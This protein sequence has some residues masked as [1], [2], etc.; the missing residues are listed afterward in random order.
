M[1]TLTTNSNFVDA[2]ARRRTEE[3]LALVVVWCRE[4]P[5]RVGE[6]LVPDPEAEPADGWRF[7]RG[8][9]GPDRLAL[10]RQRGGHNQIAGPLEL[11]R[12]SQE[13]LRIRSIDRETLELR[14]IGRRTL[15]VDGGEV[16]VSRR[17]R[18]GA[19]VEL[20]GQ[21]LLLAARRPIELPAL[22]LPDS[23]C[24]EFGRPDAF[25]L[26]GE[27]PPAWALRGQIWF[28]AQ[29]DVHVLIQG[30]SGVG[31]E[32]V[33]Q[34]I[35]S[36]S[37]RGARPL[38]ARNAATLPE[39]LI[40]AELFGNLRDYP[41][42]G[43]PERPGLVGAADRSS[44][45]LDEIGELSH[46]LQAHLLRLL[47]SGEYQRLGEAQTRQ[48]KLRLLA[49]TNRPVA[50]LKHDLAAR[51]RLRVSVPPLAA[52]RED[53]ALLI[54]HLIRRMAGEDPLLA[55]RF[56]ETGDPSGHPRVDA[57]L[58]R[59]LL[60]RAYPTNVR[61]LEGALWTAMMH[62]V[63]ADHSQVQAPAATDLAAGSEVDP[64]S[65]TRAQIE[66]ALAHADG[67]QDRAWRLLGLRN[68][69]Q[70]LRLL[71]KHGLG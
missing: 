6:V 42:P 40:D 28:M 61:E 49:A 19:V 26:L 12:V 53:I 5:E 4:A 63:V 69:Y 52:R 66:L 39:S 56:F 47:D 22:E 43:T 34:A 16:K 13:Q 62:S 48:A 67:V 54:P 59:E 50:E 68:R 10:V 9:Q 55:R 21:L 71:K 23:L 57:G 36:L 17:I 70:L 65:L 15:L 33:A 41:N 8:D 51:L 1:Q 11:P 30:P 20:R 14:N 58:V 7:G 37:S 3:I 25:G 18:E 29:R 60:G 46:Q 32:L 64:R 31:K 27:S 35:H 38:V 24:P 44:L 2:D 45:L